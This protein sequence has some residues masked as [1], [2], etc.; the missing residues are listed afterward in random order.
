MKILKS[1]TGGAEALSALLR[2]LD[3]DA[4]VQ[5]IL[6]LT[7]DADGYTPD[8]CDALLH[9]LTK[10]VFGGSF[11]QILHGRARMESGIVAVGLPWVVQATLIEGLSDTAAD[12]DAALEAAYA[13]PF[14]G[15]TLFAFVDGFSTRISALIAALYNHFGL[16]INYIG[17]GGGSLT[18]KQKPCVFSN[19]GLQQNVAVLALA[20]HKI[21]VG[22]AHGWESISEAFKVTGASGNIIHTLDWKPAFEV[23]KSVV[24]RHAGGDLNREDFFATAK[25]YPFGISK[26]GAEVV[27]RDPLMVQGDALVCVGEV[28]QGAFVHILNG[29]PGS[30]VAAATRARNLAREGGE[31]R[32]APEMQ[33]F[34]DCI[35]RVLFLEEGFQQELDAVADDALPMVGVLSIGEIAN[36]GRDYLEF[37]N[38]TAVVGLL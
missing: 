13:E 16:E 33:L 37:Y 12:F 17:G 8:S 24:D 35:S 14:A 10:P 31:T 18:L 1:E 23:Y 38:K 7:S 20:K 25:A 29:N 3:A 21:G 34:V 15:G 22:V 28:P 19:Q 2:Q 11:P 32:A 4:T 5:S 26:L 36:S 6:V 30:L 9:A 27:V